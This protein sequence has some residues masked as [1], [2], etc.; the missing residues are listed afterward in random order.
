MLTTVYCS[1]LSGKQYHAY[2]DCVGPLSLYV[3]NSWFCEDG[4]N[5][6]QQTAKCIVCSRVKRSLCGFQTQDVGLSASLCSFFL[7]LPPLPLTLNSLSNGL[8]VST[9]VNDLA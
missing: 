6:E 3:T 1:L 5:S 9:T 8:N 7:L 4:L 2:V